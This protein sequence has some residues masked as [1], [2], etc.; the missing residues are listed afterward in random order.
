[1]ELIEEEVEFLRAP[2]NNVLVGM[3]GSGKT[4][5]LFKLLSDWPYR[6]RRGKIVYMYS[7]WQPA[8]ETALQRF[9]ADRIQF[10]NGLRENLI[11]DETNWT[12]RDGT[13]DVCVCDD[14]NDQCARS[15]SFGRLFTV[16]SH[17]RNILAF[18]LTQNPYYH[19]GGRSLTPT[20]NRNTHYF[21]LFKMPQLNVLRRENYYCIIN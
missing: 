20:I 10:V 14:L 3:T 15:E 7:V 16:Y 18:F 4:S 8:F 21:V 2:S 17:H 13:C 5:W 11:D 12:R 1:M 19:Q 6:C 9:G